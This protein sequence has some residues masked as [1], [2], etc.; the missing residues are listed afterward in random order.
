MASRNLE[1]LMAEQ[2]EVFPDEMNSIASWAKSEK[3]CKEYGLAGERIDSKRGG[4]IIEYKYP[5]AAGKITED[6]KASG[7]VAVVKQIKK[8]FNGFLTQQKIQRERLFGVGCDGSNA[9]GG[10]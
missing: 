5:R 4:V 1:N 10:A 7:T 2:A 8:R 6:P 3:G 9:F